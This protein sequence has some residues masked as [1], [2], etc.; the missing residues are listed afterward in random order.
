MT[1]NLCTFE[2]SWSVCELQP[3]MVRP[4]LENRGKER[5]IDRQTDT[6]YEYLASG[7]NG[8]E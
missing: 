8:V 6:V 2:A 4:F 5:D 3:Y 7:W 1:A